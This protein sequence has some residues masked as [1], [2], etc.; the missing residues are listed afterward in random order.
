MDIWDSS[1]KFLIDKECLIHPSVHPSVRPS[2]CMHVWLWLYAF[3]TNDLKFLCLVVTCTQEVTNQRHFMDHCHMISSKWTF[4][5]YKSQKFYQS[6]VLSIDNV[7]NTGLSLRFDSPVA[8]TPMANLL[9][10]GWLV[11]TTGNFTRN[12]KGPSSMLSGN[13]CYGL[14]PLLTAL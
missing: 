8:F 12:I 4:W 2:A 9:L 11:S 6:T 7:D 13:R 3:I 5:V 10:C 14:W 1:W